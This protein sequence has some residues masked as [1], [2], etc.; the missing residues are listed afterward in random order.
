MPPQTTPPRIPHV[1]SAK[2]VILGLLIAGV[3]ILWRLG[4]FD[5]ALVSVG[6]NVNRCIRNAYGATFCGSSAKEYCSSIGGETGICSSFAAHTEPAKS[7][8]EPHTEGGVPTCKK[9]SES[10]CIEPGTGGVPEEGG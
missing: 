2:R 3:F 6:L 5:Q 4:T 7:E 9:P 1:G 8:E 10:G